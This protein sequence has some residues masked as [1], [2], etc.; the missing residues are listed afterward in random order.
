M[1]H[2]PIDFLHIDITCEDGSVVHMQF[3]TKIDYRDPDVGEWIIE[4]EGT[5]AE[6]NAEIAKSP[7]IKPVSWA[8]VP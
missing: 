7:W 6:I 2:S 1:N 3:L 5:D 8:R 4:R